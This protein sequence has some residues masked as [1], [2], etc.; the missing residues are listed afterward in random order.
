M[1][2]T[3]FR[4][5]RY[6]RKRFAFVLAASAAAVL[7]AAQVVV[8]NLAS[9]AD[10]EVSRGRPVLASSESGTVDVAKNA[11]DGST[12]TRWT[13]V[14]KVDPQWIRVDLGARMKLSRVTLI[15]DVS[16]AK[17]YQ[18]QV[19]DNGTSFTTVFTTSTGDGATDDIPLQASGRYV[20]M[21]GTVRCRD[22]GYSLQEFRIFGSPVVSP[23]PTPSPTRTPD[24][25]VSQGK[26]AKASSQA[27]TGTAAANAVDGSTATRWTS[28]SGVDPQWIR[29]DLGAVYLISKV[30]LM[31]D[32]A[33]AKA[34]QI[35]VSD[36]GSTFLNV[37]LTTNAD[38]G[39]DDIPLQASGRYVRMFGTARCGTA[40]YSVREFKVFGTPAP[41][42]KW[43][44]KGKPALASTEASPDL[45][46]AR[47]VDGDLTTGWA[48]VADPVDSQWIRVDL[49]ATYALSKVTVVWG[50]SYAST[51]RIQ[52]SDND[53][54]YGDEFTTAAG[55]G[56]TDDIY[57]NATGRYLRLWNSFLCAT[58]HQAV[59]QELR[60]YGTPPT[61]VPATGTITI[62]NQN[63]SFLADPYAGFSFG[64]E[65]LNR[66]I[67]QGNLFQYM[68]TLGTGVMRFGGS[69]DENL[70]WTSTNEPAPTWAEFTLT[71]AHLQKLNTLAVKTGWKVI[72]GLNLKRDEPAR[73]ADEA[74]FAQQILGP[75]LLALEMGNEPNYWLN[76]SPAQY[77]AD[78]QRLR[79]AMVA[80]APGVPLLG[81]SVGRVGAGDVYLNDFADRQQAHPDLAVLA[82]H[83]YPSC[84]RSASNGKINI[85]NLLSVDWHN[86]ERLRA[87]LIAGLAAR[88][89]VPG[90]L[91]ETNSVSCAGLA[92]VSDVFAAALWG[93][94]EMMSVAEAGDQG[95]LLHGDLGTCDSPFYSP[96][97]AL[98][99]DDA[100]A[101]RL[102]V[103]PVYYAPLLVQQVGTGFM[104]PVS[105]DATTVV[106][107]YAVRNGTRLRLVL[108]NVSDPTSSQ[109]YPVK[110]SLGTT[111]THGDYFRLSAPGLDA[112]SGITLGGKVVAADGTFPG[113]ARTALTVNGKTLSLTL[114]AGSATVVTLTP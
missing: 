25:L 29:V 35:Q 112:S 79:T 47:A 4:L 13:S 49:G 97:C 42:R 30:T 71:P 18:I 73:A 12:A 100:A 77:Y 7:V 11:V 81:P 111:Y 110:I 48:S 101:G 57:L 36:D 26:P 54:D 40:G 75:R 41:V 99:S 10:P 105:N 60:V 38:G 24:P 106:R 102:R 78:W 44:S 80:A 3:P 27:G 50:A 32:P 23:S 113:V 61:P 68:K 74:K 37:F 108:V 28:V 17:A 72:L 8:A 5:A 34:Y 51:Y 52:V 109:G 21:F 107:A 86:R 22:A 98:T 15:W 94:D 33:C 93:V 90:M 91:T 67:N 83:F 95:L 39:T 31:W 69:T 62:G 114:P 20:R 45:A 58:C 65:Q 46:A 19:S 88:L 9:A 82:S 87:D 53:V 55:D 64:I 59:V 16:C 85:P 14:A 66:N 43:L 2:D 56:G 6:R 103:R 92:G 76:Y 63:G 1:R 89:H 104:Q 84:S 70:W 96:M